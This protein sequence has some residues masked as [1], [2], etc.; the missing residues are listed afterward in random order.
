LSEGS[1][2]YIKPIFH[3]SLPMR[4]YTKTAKIGMIQHL[5]RT[6]NEFLEEAIRIIYEHQTMEEKMWHSTHCINNT[7]FNKID[8]PD[9]SHYANLITHHGHLQGQALANARRRMVKYARQLADSETIQTR[10]LQLQVQGAIQRE[11][12]LALLIKVGQQELWIPKS[13]IYSPYDVN[14][15][16]NQP[17]L[18]AEW[19]M[20]S[21][22]LRV[23]QSL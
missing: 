19:F 15:N 4:I 6:N 7:G 9:L 12:P 8:A 13:V 20:Q 18:L 21:K 3:R 17:F 1:E 11:T 22:G 14:I 23:T 2:K 10:L 16:S 5:L